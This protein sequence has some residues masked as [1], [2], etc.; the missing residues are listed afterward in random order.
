MIEVTI[1]NRKEMVAFINTISP[2]GIRIARHAVLEYVMGD[3]GHGLMHYVPYKYISV[4]QAGGWKSDKQRRFVMAMI[5]EGRIDPGVP[6]RTGRLQ[7]AWNINQDDTKIVNNE[8]Y[9]PFV[10]GN[11]EQ[12]RGHQLRGWRVVEQVIKNNLKGA[13]RHANSEIKKW[14]DKLNK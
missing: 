2:G 8:S 10:M 4:K 5:R 12:T 3:K 7:R 9:A 14:M 11:D 6:H 13:F 1:K